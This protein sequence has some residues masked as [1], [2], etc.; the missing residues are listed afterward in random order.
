MRYSEIRDADCAIA[1]AL[2]V[3]GDWWTLLVIRDLA[4]GINRFSSLVEELGVSRRVL[5]ERLTA[6]VNSGVVERRRYSEHPPRDEYHLT[7]RG[8]ALLPVL[9]ALQE[10]GDRF[11]FGDGSLSATSAPTS[12]EAK[13]VHELVGTV[14]PA[15][16]LAS[17]TGRPTDPVSRSRWTILYC[18]PGAYAPGTMAYPPGWGEIP[19]A[20]GC[21]VE[22][23]T[24]RDRLDEFAA[25][26]A[27]IHGVSTQPPDQLRAFAEHARVP[28]RLLSDEQHALATALRLPSFRAAGSSR[29]KR[30]TLVIDRR[31]EVRGALY[32]IRDPAGSVQD[33]LAL[34]DELEDDPC[35]DAPAARATGAPT[36]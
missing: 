33:V 24:F 20:T 4:G 29:L 34:I 16:K 7:E 8:K 30:L 3:V 11:V 17:T 28:Y 9:V 36:C 27:S 14:L 13:R 5:A 10:W 31:R 32:P 15:I 6:L 25:R 22:S 2:A 35:V 23:C 18:F 12:P 26:G 19:G 21:T 1:Q